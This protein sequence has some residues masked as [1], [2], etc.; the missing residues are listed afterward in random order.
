MEEPLLL[1]VEGERLRIGL[2]E[3]S[4]LL[5]EDD[6][7]DDG[8]GEERRG[9]IVAELSGLIC[10]PALSSALETARR[11]LGRSESSLLL[12]ELL[13]EL[14]EEELLVVSPELEGARRSLGRS[15]SSSTLE[16]DDEELLE[17]LLKLSSEPA[18][19]RSR[20]RFGSFDEAPDDE[21]LDE[22]LE[23]LLPELAEEL[24]VIG[25]VGSSVDCEARA[26]SS[27]VPSLTSSIFEACQLLFLSCLA[28]RLT[29]SP[30]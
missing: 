1:P 23:E 17:E 26:C 29:W 19:R 22:P 4:E 30:G 16:A 5:D 24:F 20:G 15:G 12:E 11:I 8:G 6:D 25:C 28:V 18:A 13:E 3:S 2:S 21:A 14:P 9:D 27:I 10:A 7:E